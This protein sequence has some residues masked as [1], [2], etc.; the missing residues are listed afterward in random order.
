MTSPRL[1]SMVVLN[2]LR[3]FRRRRG[4]IRIAAFYAAMPG[5]SGPVVCWA[6]RQPAS[7]LARWSIPG[8][9]RGAGMLQPTGAGLAQTLALAYSRGRRISLFGISLRALRTVDRR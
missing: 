2:R 5:T 6:T 8:P 1:G 7:R 3:Y 9:S 4:P